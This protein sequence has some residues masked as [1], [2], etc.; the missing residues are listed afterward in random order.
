MIPRLKVDGL[1]GTEYDRPY[2]A[3]NYSKDGKSLILLTEAEMVKVS[4][5]DKKEIFKKE[6]YINADD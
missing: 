1:D 3:A 6:M 5:E 4:L 2:K